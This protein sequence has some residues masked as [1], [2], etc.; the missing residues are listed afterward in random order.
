MFE[1][2][3]FILDESARLG[4]PCSETVI[5]HNGVEIFHDVRGVRDSIGT[6]LAADERFNIYSCSKPITCAA[7]LTLLEDGKISLDDDLADYIPAFGNAKVNKNGGIFKAERRIKLHHLFTMTAGLT[8]NME[9]DEIAKGKLETDGRCPTVKMMD[10]IAEMPLIFEPGDSWN[11]SLCHDVI[12]A[13]VEIVSGKRFGLYVKD[14]IFDPC[15]MK[16]STFLLPEDEVDT[17]PSQYKG[18]GAG[19]LVDMGKHIYRYK[20]GIEYEAGGAGCITTAHDYVEFLEA[21]RNERI[22]SRETLDMMYADRFNAA[23]R[24]ASWVPIGYGYGLGIR[25]PDATGRR[26]DIGWGGAAGAYLALDEKNGISLYYA[27]HV[28]NS[29]NKNLRKDIIEAAK[30]D[31]GLDAFTEDM[32]RGE[33]SS[34][35]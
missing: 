2:V 31:L 25:V 8:Y 7:A 35:A 30:L 20:P 28:L 32:Y 9:S 21:M 29:P 6:P 15:G 22:L 23:Q 14:K 16:N 27:Q 26:T 12:A 17:L 13:V 4:V 1:N 19:G 11:Y 33:A 5:F 18:D 10:Y 3:K 24:A 34:L